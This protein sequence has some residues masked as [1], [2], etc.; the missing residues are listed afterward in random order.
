MSGIGIRDPK[1][2]FT[3]TEL[4]IYV[5][6]FGVVVS[7]MYSLFIT[8]LESYSSQEDTMEMTQDLRAAMDIM[9][10]EVRMAGYDPTRAGGIG[11]LGDDHNDPNDPDDR[12]NSD[13]NSIHF[14][15]D[16]NGD[17]DT[18]DPSGDP[19]E[20][21]NEDITYYLYT[22]QGVQKLGRRTGPPPLPGP[23]L[24]R[25]RATSPLAENITDLTFTYTYA[26]GQ[27][28]DVAGDPD[29]TKT[30]RT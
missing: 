19:N 30:G 20:D 7:A 29:N 12:Y 21:P 5:A 2:G 16:I 28:S 15:M 26:D 10:R 3:I 4:L 22:S 18:D 14:T 27:T 9:V 8:N 1:A 6:L 25:R 11:F 24:K 23:P 13:G 17:G